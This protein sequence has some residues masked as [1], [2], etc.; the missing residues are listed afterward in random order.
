MDILKRRSIFL[1]FFLSVITLGICYLVWIYM[2][3]KE[4]TKYLDMEDVDNAG[5]NVLFAILFSVLYVPWWNCKIARYLQTVERKNDIEPD[6]LAPLL[7]LFFG[8]ALHQSRIN[9]V[10]SRQHR[11]QNKA[12]T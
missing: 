11:Q 9:M 1:W 7:A 8:T 3:T 2:I 4:T 5:L 10:V 12:T 6:I